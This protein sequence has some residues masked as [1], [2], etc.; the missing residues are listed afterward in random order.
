MH[1]MIL[2]IICLQINSFNRLNCRIK[3]IIN[4]IIVIL[5]LSFLMYSN[6]NQLNVQCVVYCKSHGNLSQISRF[7]L[8]DMDMVYVKYVMNEYEIKVEKDKFQWVMSN[9]KWR[10]NGILQRR[11]SLFF[12]FFCSTYKPFAIIFMCV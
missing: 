2:K 11:C 7:I 12:F 1:K 4:R 8:M 6:W 10:M 3:W 5:W 9:N